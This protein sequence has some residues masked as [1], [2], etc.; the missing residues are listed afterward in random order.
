VSVAFAL[1][2][3]DRSFLLAYHDRDTEDPMTCST[4]P[5]VARVLCH[6]ALSRSQEGCPR[7]DVVRQL[8][9]AAL[10]RC[11]TLPTAAET[12]ALLFDAGVH[13]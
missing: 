6:V 11:A 13:K 10:A 4:M 3:L 2:T 12:T 9:E 7:A 1:S 5:D 8:A